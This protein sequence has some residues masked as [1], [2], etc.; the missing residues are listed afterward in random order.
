MNLKNYIKNIENFPKEG[1]SFKD[2][3][4]LVATPEA[5]REVVKQL[6]DKIDFSKVDKIAGFDARGF[7]FGPLL[8][9]ELDIPFV[10][11]RK[12]GKLPGQCISKSYDLEYGSNT[13]E[14]QEGSISKGERVLL[15]GDLL[16]TGG[17]AKCGCDLVE[18]LEG[19]VFALVFIIE[20]GFLKGREKLEGYDC[21]S[22]ID[23]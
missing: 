6:K 9:V 18:E 8:S 10:V 1:I 21:I 12:K 19:E 2:I 20:L 3:S 7:I 4:P 17:T 22:L 14:M 13:I 5:L 15:I 16:A 23:Y 11:I